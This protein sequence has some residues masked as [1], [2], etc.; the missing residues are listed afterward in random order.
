MNVWKGNCWN[1]TF[2]DA[3]MRVSV[4]VSITLFAAIF[5]SKIVA[6]A[7]PMGAAAIKKDPAIVSQP[8]LTTIVD[9]TSVLIYL[10]VAAL[11]ILQFLPQA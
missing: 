1:T 10:G 8:M 2:F 7:L 4:S 9:V 3:A 11:I 5:L 6:V